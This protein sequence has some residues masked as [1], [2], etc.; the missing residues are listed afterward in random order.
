MVVSPWGEI[1]ASLGGEQI[2][3]EEGGPEVLFAEIDL[4]KVESARSQIPLPRRT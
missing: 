2:S 3:A 4:A 1:V